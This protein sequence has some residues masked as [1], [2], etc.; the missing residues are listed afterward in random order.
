VG[1]QVVCDF[2]LIN[3]K[4]VKGEHTLAVTATDERGTVLFSTTVP[5]KVTGGEKYGELL[6][7]EI[8][9]P[10]GS[11]GGYVRVS[12]KLLAGTAVVTEGHDEIYA[13]DYRTGEIPKG[14]AVLD[15]SGNVARFLT[16][17]KYTAVKYAEADAKGKVPFVVAGG[18]DP[19]KS[20]YI[21]SILERVKRDGTTLVVISYT[22]QWANLLN[23]RKV[24]K[25]NGIVTLGQ[26]WTG[27]GMFVL[28]HPLFANLPHS[29]AM[30]WEYQTVE[31]YWN[32]QKRRYG[33]LLEGDDAAVGCFNQ[34]DLRLST[35]VGVC[36]Y[37]N[38]KIILSTLDMLSSL[39][40]SDGTMAVSKRIFVNY[41]MSSGSPAAAVQAGK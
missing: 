6:V 1:S 16:G 17:L 37:G 22:E 32:N 20:P 30:N 36:T 26:A 7:K 31:R 29:Q 25:C 33:L 40:D 38:G 4:D 12:A 15:G 27:G 28:N 9:V 35:A 18:D 41:L 23:D 10:V 11:V 8:A 19:T 5:V 14:G 3:E 21:D 2:F 34:H 24:I 39:S 13:V